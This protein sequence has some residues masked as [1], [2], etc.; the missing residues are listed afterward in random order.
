MKI[1]HRE[2]FLKLSFWALAPRQWEKYMFAWLIIEL[3]KLILCCQFTRS[4]DFV[5]K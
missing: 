2:S 3:E 1:D 4:N 5:S